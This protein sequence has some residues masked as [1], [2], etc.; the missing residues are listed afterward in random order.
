MKIKEIVNDM[1]AGEAVDWLIENQDNFV[2]ISKREYEKLLGRDAFLEA[3]QAAG[4]DNWE[5]YCEAQ[6]ILDEC[7]LGE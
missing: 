3:L 2:L 4:V 6:E 7:E 1:P 5:G